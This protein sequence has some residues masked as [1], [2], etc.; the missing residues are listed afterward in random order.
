M[1]SPETSAVVEDSLDNVTLEPIQQPEF[2]QEES[3]DDGPPIQAVAETA[4]VKYTILSETSQQKGSKLCDSL[5]FTYVSLYTISKGVKKWR[6]ATHNK[7]I[8]CTA[9]VDQ[10]DSVFIRCSNID[11]S[12]YLGLEL[13]QHFKSERRSM[14]KPPR[15]SLHQQLTSLKRS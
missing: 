15:M 3:I 7:N 11:I 9:K 6:C 8:K 13:L 12:V 14:M 10:I 5:G 2:P 1:T 4:P